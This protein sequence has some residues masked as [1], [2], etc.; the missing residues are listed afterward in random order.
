MK[1]WLR[2]YWPVLALA[3]G[4]VIVLIY[5]K[6]RQ[7]S[8]TGTNQLAATLP[9]WGSGGGGGVVFQPTPDD[10][11]GTSPDTPPP[12]LPP[13][14]VDLQGTPSGYQSPVPPGYD[15][16]TWLP[17]GWIQPGPV[18]PIGSSISGVPLTLGDDYTDLVRTVSPMS[19]AAHSGYEIK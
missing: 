14:Q 7:A 10:I 11:P 2:K 8:T 18:G 15:V 13:G 3:I 1:E 12:V 16:P 4:G 6:S 9:M 17:I 5:L 19:E